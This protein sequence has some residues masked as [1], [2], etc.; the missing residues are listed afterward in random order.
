MNSIF[1]A[2]QY[3]LAEYYYVAGKDDKTESLLMAVMGQEAFENSYFSARLL[4]YPSYRGQHHELAQKFARIYETSEDF[5]DNMDCEL[6]Y[7]SIQFELGNK[8]LAF[9]LVEN[10]IANARKS[11]NKLKIV[12]GDLLKLR[13]L[14]ETNGD[15]RVIRNLFIEAVTY[16]AE[17]GIAQPFWFERKLVA[18]VFNAFKMD[19]KK[20]LTAESINFISRVLSVDPQKGLSEEKKCSGKKQ[21]DGLTEREKEV[22]DELAEGSTNLQIAEKLCV[23]LATIKTHINNIYGKLEV[24]NR[25]AVVNKLK[26][27]T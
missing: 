19:F 16:A 18:E 11:Q 2:Y 3:T 14:A 10:L 24:N 21:I 12:E 7:S 26:N 6:L 22:L 13:M 17:N 27:E 20:E 15:Q 1:Q 5:V 4:R 9:Q 25:V 23:S 8:E